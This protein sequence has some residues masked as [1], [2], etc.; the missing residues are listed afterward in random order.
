[1][2]RKSIYKLSLLLIAFFIVGVYIYK[3][4][5]EVKNLGKI[6]IAKNIKWE[7]DPEGSSSYLDVQYEGKIYETSTTGRS[8]L[9]TGKYYFVKILPKSS[10]EIVQILEEIPECILNNDIPKNGWDSIPKCK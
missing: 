1:M 8:E 4:K 6:T 9:I 5:N 10:I 2:N 3:R 7:A